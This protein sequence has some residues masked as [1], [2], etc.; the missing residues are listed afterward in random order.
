[1]T[2]A[3]PL[4]RCV[5]NAGRRS[6]FSPTRLTMTLF[7]R[8]KTPPPLPRGGDDNDNKNSATTTTTNAYNNASETNYQKRQQED[9]ITPVTIKQIADATASSA[10]ADEFALL[11]GKPIGLVTVVGKI[12]SKEETGTHKLLSIDDGT[13][14]ACCKEFA[15]E[16]ANGEA[17]E[18]K[19]E[20][21]EY[22]RVTGKLKSWN[23][24]RYIQVMNCRK[25]TDFNEVAFHFLDAMYA[26][27]RFSN[28]KG[29]GV[30]AQATTATGAAPAAYAMPTSGNNPE[31]S[32]SLQQQLLDIYNN[33]SGPAAGD[34][35]I[36]IAQMCELLGGKYT[37]EAIREAVEMLSNE[38]HVYSTITDDHHRST[39]I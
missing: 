5:S 10:E 4:T 30:A 24:A 38:G 25:I 22:V 27:S 18:A 15:S 1:M 13:G 8:Q 20:T 31:T 26:S 32:G 21:N 35:G 33:P 28:E 29:S 36:E 14:I 39:S 17:N 6:S 19:M 11:T 12:V 16:D 34:S 37:L 23:D 9:S 3:H 2:N 7:L